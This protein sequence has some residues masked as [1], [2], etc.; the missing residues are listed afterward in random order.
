MK[1]KRYE[2]KREKITKKILYIIRFFSL[3]LH[4][5][6][7]HLIILISNKNY[8]DRVRRNKN[9][10]AEFVKKV[11]NIV[12]TGKTNFKKDSSLIRLTGNRA[13]KDFIFPEDFLGDPLW[14][15]GNATYMWYT[16]GCQWDGQILSFI[17]S[18]RI[19]Q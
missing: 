17:V 11:H 14:Q 8:A 16:A 4:S 9:I 12:P 1:N 2:K 18:L 5:F 3:Y 15:I 13:A 6:I 7:Q 10:R 19:G